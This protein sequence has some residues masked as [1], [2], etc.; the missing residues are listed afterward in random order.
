MAEVGIDLGT[1]NTVVAMRFHDGPRTIRPRDAAGPGGDSPLIPSVVG[2]RTGSGRA[3]DEVVAGAVADNGIDSPRVVR[4]IKR[5]MGRTYQ[6]ALRDDAVSYLKSVRLALRGDTDI[7]IEIPG[8]PGQGPR[9][10]WP[11]EI[12][13]FILAEARRRAADTLGQTVDRAVITVP[14]Y[15]GHPHRQATLLAAEAAGLRVIDLIDEPTAA[16]FAFAANA[17]FRPGE[18]VL[19]VDWGGGTFDVTV[20]RCDESGWLQSSIEGKLTLGGDD[21]DQDIVR[22]LVPRLGLSQGVLEDRANA[23]ILKLAARRCKETLSRK[24]EALFH[25]SGLVRPGT[26]T[27]IH[28]LPVEVSRKDFE[29]WIAPRIDEA[30]KIARKALDP[31]VHPEVN[32]DEIRKVLLVGGSSFIP[33]FRSALQGLLPRAELLDHVDPLEAVA[34]GAAIHAHAPRAIE[35][36]CVD[37]YAIEDDDGQRHDV[38]PAGSPVPTPAFGR[39]GYKAKTRY[40]GQTLYRIT[41]WD[42]V[43]HPSERE[44]R[45]NRTLVARNV[46]P[47]TAGT[48]VD[49]EFWL[50]GRK[51]LKA[52]CHVGG[53]VEEHPLVGSSS[54]PEELATRLDNAL[55]DAEA[56]LEVNRNGK[57]DGLLKALD[58][59]VKLAAGLRERV[60]GSDREGAAPERAEAEAALEAVREAIDQLDARV[61][62]T[63]QGAVPTDVHAREVVRGWLP[64]LEVDLLGRFGSSMSSAH[65]AEALAQIRGLRV[66]L[67]TQARAHELYVQLEQAREA[68]YEGESG[69]IRRAWY[70][71]QMLAVPRRL[72]ARL[73]KAALGA[74]AALAAGDGPAARISFEELHTALAASMAARRQF[75]ESGAVVEASPDWSSRLR[76]R[77]RW[78]TDRGARMSGLRRAVRGPARALLSLREPAFGVVG[79]RGCRPPAPGGG[80]GGSCPSAPGCPPSGARCVGL[81]AASACVADPT[82]GC[83]VRLPGLCRRLVRG[84]LRIRAGNDGRPSAR[85][86]GVARADRHGRTGGSFP[87]PGHGALPRAAG[88]LALAD[89][90]RTHRRWRPLDGALAGGGGARHRPLCLGHGRTG[91][92]ASVDRP[93]AAPRTGVGWPRGARHAMTARDPFQAR[94]RCPSCQSTTIAK[95]LWG[96]PEWSPELEAALDSGRLALGGCCVGGDQRDHVCNRCGP[97]LAGRREAARVPMKNRSKAPR[98][99]SGGCTIS[100]ERFAVVGTYEGVLEGSR[101]RAGREILDDIQA[102]AAPAAVGRV[103]GPEASAR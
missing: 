40:P 68:L 14:A 85:A 44:W 76:P 31:R 49:I 60:G 56:L 5:L 67:E 34:L 93:G 69:P 98:L 96:L 51:T 99:E 48:P 25:C 22:M 97:S 17:G 70:E 102:M 95:I 1:T 39:F 77:N 64:V 9:C 54:G 83:C 100:L 57:T 89:R 21:L 65:R 87:R 41:V 88:G 81:V 35:Q 27:P 3:A 2:F 19:V 30:M 82:R 74:H 75:A 86:G 24:T 50:D 33:A 92:A 47:S 53:G 10:Y 63:E 101:E 46:P 90:R 38:I 58:D 23:G 42:F 28:L 18:P 61:S 103:E 4:S 55:L 62:I 59:S 32:A 80:A 7:Q 78:G 66:M 36:I 13:G 52:V 16:A 73:Q 26:A 94:G 91:A 79:A 12:S 84:A 6:E 72:K 8:P 29:A 37:G 43:D 45:A 71:S 20:L 11:H 15:F